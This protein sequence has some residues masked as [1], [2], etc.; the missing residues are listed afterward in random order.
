MHACLNL[1]AADGRRAAATGQRRQ[2]CTPRVVPLGVG[3]FLWDPERLHW[4]IYITALLGPCWGNRLAVRPSGTTQEPLKLRKCRD[5]CTLDCKGV[6]NIS[7]FSIVQP[8]IY[9]FCD[10]GRVYC[11]AVMEFRLSSSN[12]EPSIELYAHNMVA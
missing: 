7:L 9:Y 12:K 1:R 10:L 6:W 11:V 4:L 3:T 2:A 8:S 5:G